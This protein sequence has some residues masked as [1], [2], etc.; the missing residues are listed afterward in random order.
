MPLRAARV[1]R[2]G[3]IGHPVARTAV[4]AKAVTPRPRAG[5]K[6]RGC[7]RGRNAGT[8]GSPPAYLKASRSAHRPGWTG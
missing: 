3:V 1:G 5:R 8:T 2:V 4:V 7:R 6:D